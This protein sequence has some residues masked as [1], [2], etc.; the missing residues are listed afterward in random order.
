MKRGCVT[1]ATVS[2][3]VARPPAMATAQ[4]SNQ[5][6]RPEIEFLV[7]PQGGAFEVIVHLREVCI[8]SFPEKVSSKALASSPDFEIKLWGDEGIAVRAM[9]ETAKPTT[10]AIATNSGTVKVN[11]TLAVVP[12]D[13]AAYTLVRFKAVSA[14]EAF[15][16]QLKSEVAKRV[17]P[18]EN[19]LASL[20]QNFE[21]HIRER[22]DGLIAERLLKRNET[23]SFS[24]HE[25]NDD[26]VIVHITRG[27]MVGDDGYIVFDIENR[28]GSAYRLSGVRVQADG[29]DVHGP[30]RITSPSNDRDQSVIGV[31][32]ARTTAHGIVVVH[33]VD[34]ILGRSLTVTM[35][36][37]PG[38]QPVRLE[39][40]IV[41]R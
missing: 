3:L 13:K 33:A 31:V 5:G 25:R 17:A 10:V 2:L 19:Q 6:S 27:V 37:P 22:A 35:T 4:P 18:L 30:A 8:L 11:I 14:E 40:G 1:I 28:S 34:Q 39:R 41:F 29:H 36:G 26:H 7:P 12:S 23:I 38:S 21:S 16:A 24:A 9:S 32:P 15:A 20:R